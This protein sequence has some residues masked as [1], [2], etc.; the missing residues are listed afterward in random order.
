MKITGGYEMRS[1]RV[2]GKL[3]KEP[4]KLG[5]RTVLSI[6]KDGGKV[7]SPSMNVKSTTMNVKS[8]TVNVKSTTAN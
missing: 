5:E 2:R 6:R 3:E 7:N 1:M 4:F 8:T